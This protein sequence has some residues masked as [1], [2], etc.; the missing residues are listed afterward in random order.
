MLLLGSEVFNQIVR[1]H[2]L[3]L[4]E[5]N[6]GCTLEHGITCRDSDR[7]NCAVLAC[8]DGIFHFH[9]LKH[10]Y[11]VRCLD[12]ISHFDV[13]RNYHTGRGASTL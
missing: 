3:F 7:G 11:S 6:E 8:M 2:S 5:G 4:F 13:D 10:N 12:D 1:L 9:S